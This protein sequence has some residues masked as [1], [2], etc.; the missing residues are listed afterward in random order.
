MDD[1]VCV[2][3]VD[4]GGT[5]TIVA[6]ADAD[7]EIIAQE[8]INTPREQGPA[9]VLGETTSALR[10]LVEQTGV[11]DIKA[12]GIGCGGPLD[13]ERGMILTAPNLPGWENL[14]LSGY[15]EGVFDAP[16]YLDND[17]NLM[18][19]GEARH[20]AGVGVDYMTYFNI[21][22]G[23]GGGIVIGGRL[24]RGCG[25]AG[26]FGHQIILPDGPACTCGKRG[27]L[28]SLCSGTSI[29]RRTREYL[30][31]AGNSAS[32]ILD[33]AGSMQAVTAHHVAGAARAGDE[34]A[35]RIWHET[36]TYLGLGV[37]NVISILNPRLVVLGGGVMEAG[38]L[39][40]ELVRRTVQDRAMNQLAADAEIVTGQLGDQAGI[41]GA[42]SLALEGE[43]DNDPS[44]AK[45]IALG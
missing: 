40:L 15:F 6:V 14:D 8:R 13:R 41:V 25:N 18:A 16:V 38:A 20:G 1:S 29:A 7:G 34:L 32:L 21:G 17:V 36:G 23:I 12:M 26:E 10:R 2:L 22:T 24:Y 37:A 9:S 28:E 44:R 45:W 4:I 27:C 42:I 35:L 39:L 11:L 31:M 33:L 43:R 5:K 3:G 19:L 30:Q